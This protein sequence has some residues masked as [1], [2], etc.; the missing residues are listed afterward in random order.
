MKPYMRK[1]AIVMILILMTGLTA[2]FWN[3]DLDQGQVGVVQMEGQIMPSSSGVGTGTITPEQTEELNS[4]AMD[5]GADAIIYEWNSGGGAVVASKEV[6]EVIES[7]EVP[8]VC[9]FR[10]VSASGA[11]LASLGCDTIV[12]DSMSM[13]GSIGVTGSYFEF[14][15]L[16]DEYG[17]NYVNA[18]GGKYKEIGSPFKN[19]TEE[20]T[21]VLE[22]LIDNVHNEFVETVQSDRNISEEDIEEIATG[23]M[24]L[25]FEAEEKGMV[26]TVGGRQT[27][28][29][30][31]ENLTDQE[32]STV[33]IETEEPF[34][35]L[36]LLFSE[37]SFDGLFQDSPYPLL[38]ELR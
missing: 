11:Y 17:I 16:M 3:W 19:N 27:A 6:R 33:H 15:E 13:T 35:F 24:I 21:E 36:N 20:E 34:N 38:A 1:Y 12:A 9:R 2:A 25:G 7:T 10:D 29:E 23:R 8:T 30:E 37:I 31:A 18:T 22:N 5:Q 32:L 14:S 4:K 28:I 26:D